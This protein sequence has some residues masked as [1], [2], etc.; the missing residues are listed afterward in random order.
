MHKCFIFNNKLCHSYVPII[1]YSL[2]KNETKGMLINW[3]RWPVDISLV[4][5][6]NTFDSGLFTGPRAQTEC[7]ICFQNFNDATIAQ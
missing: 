4:F 6:T 3:P 5:H 2:K 7:S 1:K